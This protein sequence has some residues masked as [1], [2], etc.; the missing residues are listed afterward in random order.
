[1]AELERGLSGWRVSWDTKGLYPA[2]STHSTGSHASRQ[3]QSW[4]EGRASRGGGARG[5]GA[6]RNGLVVACG[7]LPIHSNISKT[8]WRSAMTVRRRDD[9]M[10]ST[11]ALGGP[12]VACAK[13]WN[14][15]PING[16][17]LLTDG[18]GG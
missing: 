8:A 13:S 7:L 11:A 14:S 6:R 16:R 3:R 1:V 18:V 12:L 17:S 2:L 10:Y 9:S 5:G 15:G 4:G